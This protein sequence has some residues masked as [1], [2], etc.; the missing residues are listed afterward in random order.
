MTVSV[1]WSIQDSFLHFVI[2]STFADK[3]GG[4]DRHLLLLKCS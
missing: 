1:L 2:E 4:E 3:L